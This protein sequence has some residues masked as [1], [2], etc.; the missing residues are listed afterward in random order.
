[1]FWKMNV[2]NRVL[3]CLMITPYYAQWLLDLL[4][5]FKMLCV[6]LHL[7]QHLD[8]I[9]YYNEILWTQTCVCSELDF[10]NSHMFV[11]WQ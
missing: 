5:T 3:E 9:C 11:S 2:Y 4:T 1:M 7:R 8:N 6:C 10:G